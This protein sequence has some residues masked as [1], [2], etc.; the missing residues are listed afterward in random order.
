MLAFHRHSNSNTLPERFNSCAF[1]KRA[2]RSVVLS[3]I[4][5]YQQHMNRYLEADDF[6]YSIVS[7]ALCMIVVVQRILH[8][9][10]RCALSWPNAKCMQC[11]HPDLAITGSQPSAS[12]SSTC[13]LCIVIAYCIFP[14]FHLTVLQEE[15]PPCIRLHFKHSF[16][17]QFS[18]FCPLKYE[19]FLSSKL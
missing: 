5:R 16:I 9:E 19:C 18:R 14:W 2:I 8:G 13:H 15:I 17:T 6:G 1:S 11:K 4:V 7:D 10:S 12:C 3:N